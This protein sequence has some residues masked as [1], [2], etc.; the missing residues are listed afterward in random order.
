MRAIGVAAAAAAVLLVIPVGA[1]ASESAGPT[2]LAPDLA[3][4]APIEVVGPETQFMMTLGVDAP[5]MIDGCFLDER[6][7]KGAQRCLRFDG[8]VGNIGAGP[9][10]L[11]YGPST[12][13][14]SMIARQRL[15]YSDGSFEDRDATRT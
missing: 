7:R 15:F 8:I 4:V 3:P 11:A 2:L 9:L 5:L 13:E 1:P 6:V 12:S 14:G 10:E